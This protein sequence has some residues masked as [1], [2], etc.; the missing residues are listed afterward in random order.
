MTI[1]RSATSIFLLSP[2]IATLLAGTSSSSSSHP[3]TRTLRPSHELEVERDDRSRNYNLQNDGGE[4]QRTMGSTFGTETR[5]LKNTSRN[6][7]NPNHNNNNNNNHRVSSDWWERLYEGGNEESESTSQTQH[8]NV[9]SSK[10]LNRR[11]HSA[12]IYRRYD[13]EHRNDDHSKSNANEEG[14]YDDEMTEWMIV[15]GGFT[16]DDWNTFPVWAYDITHARR[17]EDVFA[18]EEDDGDE[19]RGGGGSSMRGPWIDLTGLRLGDASHDAFAASEGSTSSSSRPP[20]S[21]PTLSR[22]LRGPEGR[23]G[24]LTS[25]YNGCLYVFGGLTYSQGSFHAEYEAD[26][27]VLG[28]MIVWKACNLEDFF[29]DE[30][31]FDETRGRGGGNGNGKLLEWE[32]IV[33]NVNSHPPDRTVGTIDDR[34]LSEDR[35]AFSDAKRDRHPSHDHDGLANRSS[36]RGRKTDSSSHREPE[37]PQSREGGPDHPALRLPRGE[38]RGGHYPASHRRGRGNGSDDDS[39]DS[40]VFYGGMHHDHIVEDARAGAANAEYP[41][42]DVWKYEYDTETLTLLAPYPP[43]VWQRDERNG[44]YPIARTAHAGTIVG[45]ELIIHGGMCSMNDRRS[46]GDL[47]SPSSSYSTPSS[48]YATY[49]ATPK[50]Q[51]LSDVWVFDLVKL[52][53]KERYIYP[54]LARSY[55][56]LVGWGNGAVAAFGGYQQDDNIGGETIAFV[57]K[58]LI[59]SRPNETHWMK[60]Q[61]PADQIPRAWHTIQNDNSPLGISNRLE[62]S[63]VLDQYGSMLVWGGR[64]QTVRQIAGMWRIDVFTEDSKLNL[65]VAVPDG[66][67]AYEA[68]LE[69]MRIFIAILMFTSFAMSSLFGITRRQGDGGGNGGSTVSSSRRGLAREV[70]DSLPLKRYETHRAVT[71]EGDIVEDV[72]LRRENSREE[73]TSSLEDAD[74]CPI[75]LVEYEE[76][77]EI[78]VLP[79]GHFFDRGCIETWL[80]SHTNCP[81]CRQSISNTPLSPEESTSDGEES[82]DDVIDY[83]LQFIP[84]PLHYFASGAMSRILDTRR[85]DRRWFGPL[86]SHQSDNSAEHVDDGLE[87]NVDVSFREESRLAGIRRFFR[88]RRARMQVPEDEARE[89]IEL[90]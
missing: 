19:T 76:G 45:D 36:T 46:Y 42:G 56:S 78:R 40:F 67:E 20:N 38:A 1:L 90:V 77:C 31:D 83:N 88:S 11:S 37:Q 50:W 66:I 68:E 6:D 16:D 64:F 71:E 58:D 73:V 81:T 35:V 32:R 30:E 72:S 51:A 3:A 61:P 12:A 84:S 65:D 26:G 25:V 4:R 70:I 52:R 82:V 48:S 86:D 60:L 33:P 43:L 47:T 21:P 75:C 89:S 28:T 63:A 8:A 9:Q 5:S 22:P 59:I 34:E 44:G 55:H 69:S 2:M 49:T 24:H 53:W 54:Q 17:E 80:E 29:E 27:G 18:S 87:A 74:C 85:R 14:R 39:R 57:F 41:L 79:C 13:D 15:S 62:H 10:P 23:V 7:G